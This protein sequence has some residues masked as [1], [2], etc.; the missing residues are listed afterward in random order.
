MTGTMSGRDT[1]TIE[2]LEPGGDMAD[3]QNRDTPPQALSSSKL[4]QTDILFGFY[5]GKRLPRPWR[6]CRKGA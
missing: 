2:K 1:R 4:D 3:M 5:E 6:P